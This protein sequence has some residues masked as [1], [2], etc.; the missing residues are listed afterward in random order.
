M[1]MSRDLVIF[2][3]RSRNNFTRSH[4]N[5]TRS[6]NN[7]TRSHNNLS[8]LKHLQLLCIP[9]IISRDLVKLL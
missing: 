3:T 1:I 5:F 6:C 8:E 2:F 9:V 7:F 4:N